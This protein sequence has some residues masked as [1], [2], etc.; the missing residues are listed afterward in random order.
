VRSPAAP[1]AST[2]R[3][4]S[5]QSAPSGAAALPAGQGTAF[6]GTPARPNP[7]P[8]PA[9]QRPNP[10]AQE[11]A[12][13]NASGLPPAPLSK[14]A[15]SAHAAVVSRVPCGFLHPGRGCYSHAASQLPP[16][17]ARALEVYLPVYLVPALLVHRHRL[18]QRPADILPKVALGV[19]R[20]SLFLS[21]FIGLAFAGARA[22]GAGRCAACAR[23]RPAACLVRR[24]C[25]TPPPPLL[26]ASCR[27]RAPGVSPKGGLA[28]ADPAWPRAAAGIC[29][30][31]RAA[32]MTTGAIVAGSVWAGG[33][34]TLVEKKSRRME[35][36]Y[37]C[38]SRALESFARWAPASAPARAPP[39]GAG[40]AWRVA[41]QRAATPARPVL[42][43]RPGVAQV[44]PKAAAC[45]LDARLAAG[46][47]HQPPATS[48]QHPAPST[49][50]PGPSLSPTR[51]QVHRGVGLGAA[52]AAAGAAGC[53]HLQRR[54][55]RH[56]ALLQ[57]RQRAPP[58]RLPLQVPQRAGLHFR[59]HG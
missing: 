59:Q 53:A 19:A 2:Q 22:P 30:A 5:A 50:P 57:R 31:H 25:T 16:A 32:G 35:L 24:R 7:P 38:M 51:L 40:R 3:L 1:A 23:D 28:P 42:G 12:Q 18:L 26:L 20:S 11:L 4:P 6:A 33:L 43:A 17:Y 54:H 56:H 37:Y 49:Q 58:G 29:T 44:R 21:L 46:P 41:R 10:R 9:L 15:G 34:A 45:T 55:R 36:A 52:K 48:T 13:R 47:S 27:S 39:E 14:L 8:L